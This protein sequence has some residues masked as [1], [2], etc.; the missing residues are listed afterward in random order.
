MA[1]KKKPQ[2]YNQDETQS[3]RSRNALIAEELANELGIHSQPSPPLRQT[4]PIPD[5]AVD[6]NIGSTGQQ[7]HA[8]AEQANRPDIPLTSNDDIYSALAQSGT[9][10]DVQSEITSTT[11]GDAAMPNDPNTTGDAAEATME[12]TPQMS[13]VQTEITYPQEDA[14][15]KAARD[16]MAVLDHDLYSTDMEASMEEDIS[17]VGSPTASR[18]PQLSPTDVKH[19]TGQDSTSDTFMA[20]QES[21]PVAD[22]SLES[23]AFAQVSESVPVDDNAPTRPVLPSDMSNVRDEPVPQQLQQQPRSVWE[24]NPGDDNQADFGP[25]YDAGYSMEAAGTFTH[26]LLPDEGLMRSVQRGPSLSDPT[27]VSAWTDFDTR[28]NIKRPVQDEAAAFFKLSGGPFTSLLMSKG[29]ETTE[30][31][32][33]SPDP[34][35]LTHSEDFNNPS[36]PDSPPLSDAIEEEGDFAVP[37]EDDKP[38]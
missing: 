16:A 18:N 23:P 36:P 1:S 25:S 35:G 22:S 11:Q 13:S 24:G 20:Q 28:T 17:G 5:F 32:I 4:E 37:V 2:R 27:I 21:V 38:Q 29:V 19:Q 10:T 15:A 12:N 26:P 31:S 14:L 8:R 3:A 34:G 7:E 30:K 6:E 9:N 33:T